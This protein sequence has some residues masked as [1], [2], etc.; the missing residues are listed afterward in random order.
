VER[1]VA[2]VARGLQQKRE[3]RRWDAMKYEKIEKY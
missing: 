2:G 1:M 3:V